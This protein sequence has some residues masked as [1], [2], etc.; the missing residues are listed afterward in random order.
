MKARKWFIVDLYFFDI[1]FSFSMCHLWLEVSKKS[2]SKKHRFE[3][4]ENKKCTSHYLNFSKANF[5]LKRFHII[6]ENAVQPHCRI[7]LKCTREVSDLFHPCLYL[8]LVSKEERNGIGSL[9]KKVKRK[10]EK[11]KKRRGKRTRK[12]RERTKRNR[13]WNERIRRSKIKKRES[14]RGRKKNI[15]IDWFF[16]SVRL[17]IYM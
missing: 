9:K 16:S 14:K 5:F 8:T 11:G 13:N 12:K 2:L 4:F 15:I 10:Q 17:Q 6:L 1:S 7:T 3:N